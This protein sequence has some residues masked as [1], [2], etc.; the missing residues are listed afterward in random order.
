[1][2]H[3]RV[4]L[5]TAFL[6]AALLVQQSPARSQQQLAPSDAATIRTT[7]SLVFLDVTVVDKKGRPVTTA[8]RRNDFAIT[9]DNKPEGIF[10]FEAPEAHVL[11]RRN[12]DASPEGNAPVTILVLDLLNSEFADFAYIRYEV[13]RFLMSQPEMLTSPSEMLVLG[14]E[15]LEML[16]GFTRSRADLLYAL[17]HLPAALPYKKQNAS[18]YWERFDQSIDAL[19]QIGLENR[20]VPGRKNIIWVGHGGPNVN[21]SPLSALP[22]RAEAELKQYVHDTTN[23]LVDARMSLFVIYPAFKVQGFHVDQPSLWYTALQA[24]TNIGDDDPFAGDINFAVF[25]NETGGK[26]FYNRNDVDM[27][28]ARSEDLGRNYYTLT[29]QPHD[30]FPNGKF[31]RIRVTLRDPNLRA[32]TKAGYFAQDSKASSD[33]RQQAMMKLVEAAQSSLAFNALE[34]NLSGVKRHPDARTVECTVQLKSKNLTWVPTA[35]GK[36]AARL[37]FAAVSLNKDRTAMASTIRSLT[38]IATDDDLKRLP[39]VV[40]RIPLTIRT[41][42]KTQSVRVVMLAE[43]GGRMGAADIDRKT[44]DAAP[45]S[46]TSDP[47]LS[48]SPSASVRP[49]SF[50]WR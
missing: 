20:G 49:A 15:S 32:I 22:E 37:T 29:Y 12:L 9:E 11:D 24:E 21:L 14:D 30:Q 38:L 10:S 46:P 26:L 33:P 44:I 17:D 1:M 18:F 36:N 19:Q 31:R 28:I 2:S 7:S 5:S 25:V 34:V 13:R 47:Q 6:L 16:Q 39:G 42:N 35:N 4:T 27:E 50:Q 48:Q 8:L 45:A 3:L 41:P 40:S 23:M 43:D